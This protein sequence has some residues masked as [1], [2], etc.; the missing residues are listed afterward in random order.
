M[1]KF[2][3]SVRNL[4]NKTYRVDV[5]PSD[6]I[7]YFKQQ[8]KEKTGLSLSPLSATEAWQVSPKTSSAS[9]S[10]ERRSRTTQERFRT[11]GFTKVTD[12]LS[13]EHICVD[14]TVMLLS[15]L[16]GGV[17]ESRL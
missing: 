1:E 2:P 12:A 7:L 4:N 17:L 11:T 13:S 6:K 10:A 16:E 9:C 14:C 3:V 5:A 15:R 8:L